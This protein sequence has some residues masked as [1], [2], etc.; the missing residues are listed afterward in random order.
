M[1]SNFPTVSWTP[2]NLSAGTAV[3]CLLFVAVRRELKKFSHF[4]AFTADTTEMPFPSSLAHARNIQ[5]SANCP[6]AISLTI[7]LQLHDLPNCCWLL[8]AVVMKAEVRPIFKSSFRNFLSKNTKG[9]STIV[10]RACELVVQFVLHFM[11]PLLCKHCSLQ[12]LYT[13]SKNGDWLQEGDV[14]LRNCNAGSYC[15]LSD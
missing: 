12:L 4:P 2:F 7:S 3:H 11:C 13:D 8:L 14:V 10:S 6:N 9:W 1:N 15:I 5:T